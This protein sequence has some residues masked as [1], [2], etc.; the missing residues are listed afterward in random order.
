MFKEC[1]F[2]PRLK[3]FFTHFYL[4]PLAR[5]SD[6]LVRQPERQLGPDAQD[7]NYQAIDDHKTEI[8]FYD[9]QQLLSMT[10]SS[11]CQL[12]IF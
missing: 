2:N 5:S 4:H 12:K 9:K 6:H 1:A 11:G 7:D 10:I 8:V 3:R